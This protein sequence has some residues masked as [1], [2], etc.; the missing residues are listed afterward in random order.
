MLVRQVKKVLNSSVVLAVD[1][2]GRESILLGKG[3][4]WGAKRGDTITADEAVQ[5]FLPLG[6]P[7]SRALIELLS[8][9]PSEYVLLAQEII[10][11]AGT[12]LKVDLHP[13]LLLALTDHLH[14]AVERE[15]QGL[16]VQNG[17][18]LEMRSYYP[19]EY[20]IGMQA[21]Q[22]VN[23]RLGT[24]LPEDEAA[25]IAFHL[26][27]ARNDASTSFN[28]LRAA[29]LISEIVTIVSYALGH[30]FDHN[31]L[32]HRRFVTHLQF[33][34][35]RFFASSMLDKDGG[36]LYGLMRV[37]YPQAVACAEQVRQHVQKEYEQPLPDEEVGYLALHIER[38]R[39]RDS[40]QGESS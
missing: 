5:V 37:R 12:S 33:F 20:G 8:S 9:I 17:L 38:L 6:D 11:L 7:D 18:A 24:H 28:A 36:F 34:A 32:N 35:D 26:V 22:L 21:L 1:D 19:G 40:F 31:E 39:D 27:N 29:S 14:F 3:I 10:A 23:E 2:S 15:K 25:N 16:R 30:S 13:H 4:G